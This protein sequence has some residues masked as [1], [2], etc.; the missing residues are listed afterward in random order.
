MVNF[1]CRLRWAMCPDMQ[2]TIL[3]DFSCKGVFVDE[4]NI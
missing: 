4:I 2:S 3:L 1:M